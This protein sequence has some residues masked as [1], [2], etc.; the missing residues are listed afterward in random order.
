M[1]IRLKPE[2][3]RMLYRLGRLDGEVSAE[4]SRFLAFLRD[5]LGEFPDSEIQDHGLPDG[6]VLAKLAA[7]LS[8]PEEK[9]QAYEFAV[10]LTYL[11]GEVHPA[12]SQFLK[13]LAAALNLAADQEERARSRAEAVA[14]R[15]RTSQARG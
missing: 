3:F 4:E 11:D 10:V 2:V 13:K 8:S 5:T 12:E 6:V 14:Q 15:Y 1:T 9:E 7:T